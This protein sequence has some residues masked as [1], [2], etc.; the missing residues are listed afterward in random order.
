MLFPPHSGS[1]AIPVIY[2]NQQTSF[3]PIL[4]NFSFPFLASRSSSSGY[5]W[6]KC[7][8]ASA[9]RSLEFSVLA[10]VLYPAL[11]R[12]IRID[13]T[14][15]VC[16]T[17][18]KVLYTF[19]HACWIDTLSLRKILEFVKSTL[20][21]SLFKTHLLSWSTYTFSFAAYLK[22][23]SLVYRLLAHQPADTHVSSVN[24]RV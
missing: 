10:D 24:T 2:T 11:L 8:R 19:R 1:F 23:S 9:L 3:S 20:C 13:Y 17:N 12:Y 21:N 18:I 6:L 14:L 22:S 4:L 7:S 16:G 5:F 15:F